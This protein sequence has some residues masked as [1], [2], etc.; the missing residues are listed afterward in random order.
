M[1]KNS[2]L[3]LFAGSIA[4]TGGISAQYLNKT[5]PIAAN[6][7]SISFSLP[8]LSGKQ[9]NIT[10]WQGKVRIIN[11]WATWCPPCL[12][13]IPEFIN[14]QNEFRDRGIQFIG[15]AIED[16]KSVKKYLSKI[17]INY[18][19]LIGKDDGIAL[20]QQL[21]NIVNA[22]PFTVVTNQQGQIIHRQPG[23]F[24]REQI[25]KVIMH[26]I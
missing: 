24:S 22:V 9:R 7:P 15:I 25:L 26:L 14:L 6:T 20:S 5:D 21:G 18:P 2:F 16:K 11:F 23:E 12:K 3:I 1:N 19:I 4:L 13:E 8:D 17:N 10:E